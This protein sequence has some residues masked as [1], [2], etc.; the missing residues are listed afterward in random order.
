MRGK[1]NSVPKTQEHCAIV[2][3][4]GR[5][6]ATALHNMPGMVGRQHVAQEVSQHHCKKCNIAVSILAH[7][8]A[9]FGELGPNEVV[10]MVLL[11]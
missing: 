11:G 5:L 3:L 4:V 10:V 7:W 8:L 9:V 6:A 2:T 1:S